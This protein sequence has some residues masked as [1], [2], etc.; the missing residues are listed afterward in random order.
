MSI[1][2]ITFYILTVVT[3][4]FSVLFIERGYT[5]SLKLLSS[6]VNNDY[7]LHLISLLSWPWPS[8]YSLRVSD[9]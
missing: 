5:K 6:K 2:C 7:D 4:I 9:V 8:Y 1:N 3:G